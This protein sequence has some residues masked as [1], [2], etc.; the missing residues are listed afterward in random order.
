MSPAL[1][2]AISRRVGYQLTTKFRLVLLASLMAT[3]LAFSAAPA[4]AYDRLGVAAGH[5]NDVQQ[6][7]RDGSGNA[8][9]WLVDDQS[10]GTGKKKPRKK[11]PHKKRPP[12]P[13][14]ESYGDHSGTA[15]QP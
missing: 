15:H 10:S 14:Q 2:E 7:V 6:A 3:G 1:L 11:R 12:K 13:P 8:R 5:A 9:I 4:A